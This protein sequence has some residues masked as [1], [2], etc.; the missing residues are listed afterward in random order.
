MSSERFSGYDNQAVRGHRSAWDRFDSEPDSA[1]FDGE[2]GFGRMPRP[3]TPMTLIRFRD[4][5]AAPA[6]DAPSLPSAVDREPSRK[7]GGAFRRAFLRTFLLTA[8]WL[9]GLAVGAAGIRF[10]PLEKWTKAPAAPNDGE[11]AVENL[12]AEPRPAVTVPLTAAA[13]VSGPA[14]AA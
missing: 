11:Y 7:R 3:E 14:K 5:G 1:G 9:F 10:L 4:Y 6:G 13:A 2:E 12:A 8:V